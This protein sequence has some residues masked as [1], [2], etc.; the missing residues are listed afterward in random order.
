MISE[1]EERFPQHDFLLG[2]AHFVE[3]ER[4]ILALLDDFGGASP[5]PRDV[6]EVVAYFRTILADI[7]RWKPS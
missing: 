6:T 4:N 2:D 5:D 1:L 7:E 3:Y